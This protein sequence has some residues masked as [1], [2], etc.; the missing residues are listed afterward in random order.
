MA[1][2]SGAALVLVGRLGLGAPEAAPLFR[3][4]LPEESRIDWVHENALSPQR[5]LP[6]TTGAGAAIFDFDN[7]GWMDVY[8]VNSGPCDLYRPRVPLSNALYR[9]NRDGTFTDVTGKA[10]VPGGTFG[11]GAAVGDYDNDGWPDLYVTSYGKAVLYRNEGN[12]TFTD[13][14]EKAGVGARGWTT[15]AVFFD[16]DG[17]GRL[18]LFAGN[19]VRYGLDTPTSCSGDPHGKRYFCVPRI[20]DPVTSYLFHNEGGGRFADVS[21][22]TGFARAPGKALG[23]VATDFNNDGLLDLFVTNDTSPNHLWMNRGGGRWEEVAVSAFVAFSANGKARS[24]MGVDSADWDGDGWQDVAIGNI[25]HEIF[26]LY[27]NRRD[28]SFVDEAEPNGLAAATL[29][30]SCWGLKLFDY[31]NDGWTDLFLANGHP[32]DMLDGSA[33]GV[34]YRQPPLLFHNEGGRYR[35]VSAE[36]GPAFRKEMSARGLAVG[37]LDNDGRVDVLVANNGMA[38][39]LLHN[40]SAARNHWLGVK[41]QGTAANRDAVGALVTWSA[42]GVTRQRLKTGGGSYLSSHDP[43]LVLGL[44]G[45]TRVDWLEVRWPRPSDRVER[46]TDLP[47]DRYVTLVEATGDKPSVS[48]KKG[49]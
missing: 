10:G 42:G 31:D 13:V 20:F 37:D 15:S 7:D 16:Y 44:G 3:E 29:V 5:Y 1:I 6:E 40:E 30:I 49:R 27:R 24:S 41:L 17:D 18:D 22:S 26:A 25:D 23:V 9:N 48:P 28:E 2:S 33:Y 35:N 39:L 43:R 8:L 21:A 19:Y 34:R 11:M 45:A 36:A 46:F 47:V 14:T 38:P 4:V 12:G 32:D